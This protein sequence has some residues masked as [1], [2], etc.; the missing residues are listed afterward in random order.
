MSVDSWIRL[1]EMW[2]SVWT[3]IVVIIPLEIKKIWAFTFIIESI[4]QQTIVLV[5]KL[6]SF[7][8]WNE[9]CEK[10]HTNNSIIETRLKIVI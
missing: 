8:S 4:Q 3:A 9:P 7:E 1:R 5:L 2:S 10:G 6:F